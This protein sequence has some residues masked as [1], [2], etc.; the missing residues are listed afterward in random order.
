MPFSNIFQISMTIGVVIASLVFQP[1]AFGDSQTATLQ[2]PFVLSIDEMATIDSDLVITLLGIEEDSRCPIDVTC[3]WEG[4]VKAEI[5]LVNGQTNLG[6]H[7]IPL[8]VKD[9][10][11]QTFDGYFIK[12]MEV[13]PYPS[14]SSPINPSE[15]RVTFLVSKIKA[16]NIDSPLKQFNSGVPINETQ[17]RNDLIL[18]IKSKNLT[19]ACVKPNTAEKLIVREWAK[20]LDTSRSIQPIIKTGTNSGFCLGYCFTEFTLTSEKIVYSQTGRKFVSDSWVDLPEKTTTVPI[21]QEEW[22]ELVDA[23]DFQKFNSL[24]DKIGCPGCADAPV[25]WIEISYGGK[26]KKIEFE[27]R[28]SIPEITQLI[29]KL[30]EIRDRTVSSLIDSFEDCVVAGNPVME[31]YPRQ[32]RTSDGRNFVE[33]TNPKIMNPDVQCQNYNG[34]WLP[35]FNECEGISEERCSTMNGNFNECESACRHMPDSEMCT[36]QCVQVCVIPL[37]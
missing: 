8:A 34:T 21:S 37:N 27:A 11:S 25:E 12:I 13:E 10:D 3:V 24:P 4:S 35:D 32:C 5:N 14:S 29:I 18:I 7:N 1:T 20:S 36:L 28:E 17:C 15:Y 19:P 9:A 2:T 6:N 30:Q 33:D 16:T 26:T 23:V 22:K 31:S